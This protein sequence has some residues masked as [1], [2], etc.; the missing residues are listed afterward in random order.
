MDGTIKPAGVNE[1]TG[2]LKIIAVLAM[3]VDH[4]AVVF[5][6]GELWMRV[7]G[8]LAFPLFAWSIAVGAQKTRN[9]SKYAL[10]L[11]LVGVISQPFYMI[12]LHHELTKLNVFVC[13]F[14]D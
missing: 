9:I 14:W 1:N 8:R 5:F 12:G 7:V 4:T 2:F 3:I 6:P 10:R 13:F 11:L